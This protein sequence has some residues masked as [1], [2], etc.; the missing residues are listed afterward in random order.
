MLQACL[1]RRSLAM[2]LHVTI[3]SFFL[4]LTFCYSSL[5]PT[6]VFLFFHIFLYLS[7]FISFFFSSY[8]PFL[9]QFLFTYRIPG[10]LSCFRLSWC[11]SSSFIICLV[12]LTLASLTQTMS[13][14]TTGSLM[15]NK[16]E[17]MW[18]ETVLAFSRV[19]SRN[20]SGGNEGNHEKFQSGYSVSGRDSNR[21]PHD[22]NPQMLPDAAWCTV[23]AQIILSSF[24]LSLYL[25][26]LF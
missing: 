23:V 7:F 14:Q 10:F 19:L 6:F 8:S 22:C 25:T 4:P 24:S 9:L 5:P 12:K 3:R 13:W 1:P 26:F 21:V 17:K 18:K 20:L 15:N 16:L 11:P 2:S